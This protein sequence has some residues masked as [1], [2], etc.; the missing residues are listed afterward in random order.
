LV[1][2]PD[3]TLLWE[4]EIKQLRHYLSKEWVWWPERS[5]WQKIRA[6]EVEAYRSQDWQA[7]NQNS[8]LGDGL[9]LCE[10]SIRTG[11]PIEFLW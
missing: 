6:Y 8:I 4:L 11:N 9:L 3:E 5:L 2:S 10:A 1:L 7:E